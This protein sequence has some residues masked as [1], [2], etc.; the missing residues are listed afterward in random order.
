MVSS[1]RVSLQEEED[2]KHR[3][4]KKVKSRE[5]GEGAEVAM[6]VEKPPSFREALLKVGSLS[7]DE[8]ESFKDWVDEE[9]LENRWYKDEEHPSDMEAQTKSQV[10]V[11]NVSDEE[12]AEWSKEWVWTIVVNVLGKKVNYR[13]LENKAKRDWARN[14]GVKVID[15]PRGFF[16]VQFENEADYKH[17]LFEGPWMLADHYLLM[18][19]WRPNFL[20]SAKKESKVAV[21]VRI[22]ELPLELYNKEFLKR[23]GNILGTFLKVDQLTSIHSRGKF[24]RFCAEI[25]LVK[26]L[27]PFVMFR[28]EKINLEFEGLHAVCFRC[29]VYGHRMEAYSLHEHTVQTPVHSRA[30]SGD[31]REKSVEVTEERETAGSGSGGDK[32]SPNLGNMGKVVQISNGINDDGDKAESPEVEIDEAAFGPWMLVKR[33]RKIKKQPPKPQDVRNEVDNKKATQ[34]HFPGDGK[35][36]EPRVVRTIQQ[37]KKTEMGKGA[38]VE[39]RETTASLKGSSKVPRAIL[40]DQGMEVDPIPDPVVVTVRNPNGGKNPQ[41]GPRLRDT[42]KAAR[43]NGITKKNFKVAIGP[44]LANWKENIPPNAKSP[45]TGKSHIIS[46]FN[47]AS[48]HPQREIMQAVQNCKSSNGVD[49]LTVAKVPTKVSPNGAKDGIDLGNQFEAG[50]SSKVNLTV[51]QG[52]SSTKVSQSRTKLSEQKTPT[53]SK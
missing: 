41:L 27:V 35:A 26:P 45:V 19:R 18:Q 44:V 9:L 52:V 33:T 8:S 12:L 24:A 4:T 16:A 11:I 49:N 39:S 3:A 2:P 20:N 50:D 10:P 53:L 13:M 7:G 34:S 40:E 25:D 6:E 15:M 23:V 47:L 30:N 21:W 36:R 48:F 46:E 22:P 43:A 42:K 31:E 1:A 29:G 14:G 5:E 51:S 38:Q 17:A 28:G 37:K 32:A